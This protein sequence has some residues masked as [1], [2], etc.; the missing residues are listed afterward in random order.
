M[1]LIQNNPYRQ[2]GLLVGASAK[3]E[4]NHKT[5]INQYLDADHEIPTKYIEY[6][7][8]CL[9]EIERTTESI[10]T[11]GANLI[12]G[13]DRMS[14]ALFWFWNA[15]IDTDELAFGALKKGD[16]DTAFKIWEDL[17]Q[18]TK[19][20]GKKLWKQV[21]EKNFSAYHNYFV[22]NMIHNTGNIYK[23][24]VA[25]LRF[26]ENDLIMNFTHNVAGETYKFNKKELQLLFLKKF[27]YE[28]KIK[29]DILARIIVKNTFSGK[30]EFYR[31]IIQQLTE[32][33]E[34]K[35]E[36]AKSKRK[37][38]KEKAN[39]F[40]QDL[41]ETTLTNINTIKEYLE[42]D[43]LGYSTIADKLANEILQCSID[44]FN[45]NHKNNKDLNHFEPTLKL[46][47][48]AYEIA[49]GKITRSRIKENIENLESMRYPEILDAIKVFT[50]I[51]NAY[52]ELLHNFDWRRSINE[53]KV[54]KMLKEF[55][56][57]TTVRKIVTCNN[58]AFL[59]LFIAHLASVIELSNKYNWLISR[60][61][62]NFILNNL[63][64]SSKNK[65]KANKLLIEI[66]EAKKN[67]KNVIIA[68]VAL[69]FALSVIGFIVG[70]LIDN[71]LYN[72]EIEYWIGCSTTGI[73]L[74]FFILSLI[75][76]N[77]E[78]W[79]EKLLWFV[80]ILSAAIGIAG[81]V[82]SIW[83]LETLQVIGGIILF[84]LFVNFFGRQRR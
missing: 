37:S 76:W 53:N 26:I 35:I 7:F 51:K 6:G 11:A 68:E 49:I 43:N 20:D 8:S 73:G 71:Q 69:V 61:K 44:Y 75:E 47:G 83:G 29:L 36:I 63:P 17:V 33:I 31:L 1:R 13:E 5:K 40:G 70:I 58:S 41:Y 30:D 2:L 60:C 15:N 67:R 80:A 3:Q 28:E 25:N 14:A 65:Q 57:P 48:F 42:D 21:N 59:E 45:A 79:S 64:E 52:N 38:N 55:F 82:Y 54:N 24:I 32:P 10:S 46:A 72:T 50:A 81:L 84:I 66:G 62:M 22:I 12:L 18:V 23:G 34:Q 56:T 16:V 27:L 74:G 78:N 19:E 77:R 39:I 4:S 9:G